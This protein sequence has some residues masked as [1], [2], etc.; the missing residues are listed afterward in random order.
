MLLVTG[1]TGLIG[2]ELIKALT[3]NGEAVRCLVRDPRRLGAER[4]RVQI[5]LGDLADSR[6]LANATRGVRSV[7]HMAAAHHD[8][9]SGTIEELGSIATWRLIEAAEAAGAEH[10]S[11]FS[12]L[13]AGRGADTRL[14]RDKA[15][16][17]DAV[18]AARIPTTTFAL[19]LAH[20]PLD[21]LSSA[22]DACSR[23]GFAPAP[24]EGRYQPVWVSD[25]VAGVLAQLAL[26]SGGG[27]ERLEF[28]G[29]QA[30]TTLMMTRLIVSS[31]G[32]RRPSLP[33]SPAIARTLLRATGPGPAKVPMIWDEDALLGASML[34]KRGADD[35]RSLGVEARKF[36]DVL[37]LD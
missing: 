27:H 15:L 28:A 2:S 17:E 9:D 4:V 33:V 14:L 16:A 25:I 21:P 24:G 37:G 5:V 10:F 1:A 18:A 26:P 29:P 22:I 19:S 23:L 32:R 3:A 36:S 8:Q 7:I 13:G 6:S 12:A 35:L 11:Y 20:S 34:S 31:L 30:L